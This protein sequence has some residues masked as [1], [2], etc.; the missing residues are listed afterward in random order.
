MI[1]NSEVIFFFFF[2]FGQILGQMDQ[3]LTC[4][5][6]SLFAHSLSSS[7]EFVVNCII[8]TT[9]RNIVRRDR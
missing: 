6:M 5:C 4:I 7:C 9:E 1:G 8:S 2:Q 3:T